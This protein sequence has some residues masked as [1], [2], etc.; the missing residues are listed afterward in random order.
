[1]LP[2]ADVEEAEQRPV[3]TA[4]SKCWRYHRK[5]YHSPGRAGT[6]RYMPGCPES[7]AQPWKRLA[8]IPESPQESEAAAGEIS[9]PGEE[10]SQ[11]T[12]ATQGRQSLGGS[13]DDEADDPRDQTWEPETTLDIPSSDRLLWRPK[14]TMLPQELVAGTE[15]V[16]RNSD[17]ESGEAEGD[18]TNY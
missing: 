4:S 10:S 11:Q 6:C 1:M 7:G 13:S 9:I 18:E 3:E 15:L 8:I 14:R 2:L 17:G 5:R 16:R 12:N